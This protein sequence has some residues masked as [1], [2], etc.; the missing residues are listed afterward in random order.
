M[1]AGLRDYAIALDGLVM[2][3]EC[4][5]AGHTYRR[6]FGKERQPAKRLPAWWLQRMLR[7]WSREGGGCAAFVGITRSRGQRLPHCPTCRRQRGT[8]N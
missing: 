8:S 4:G 6:D 1:A 5:K 3:F 7:Y 2:T